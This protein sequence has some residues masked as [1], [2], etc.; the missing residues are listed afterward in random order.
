MTILHYGKCHNYHLIHEETDVPRHL[1]K[2]IVSGE[3]GYAR[4]W[5]LSHCAIPHPTI[6]QDAAKCCV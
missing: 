1:S 6:Y 2:A 4:A 3:A 5:F